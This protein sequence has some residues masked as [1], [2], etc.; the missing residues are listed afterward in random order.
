MLTIVEHEE[1]ALRRQRTDHQL[2]LRQ[3]RLRAQAQSCGD[4][5]GHLIRIEYR[6]ELAKPDPVAEP[7]HQLM[8]H[9]QRQARLADATDAGQRDDPSVGQ[10]RADGFHLTVA[11]EQ[12]HFDPR[13]IARRAFPARA[14]R[15]A[16]GQGAA[17]PGDR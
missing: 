15:P 4:G 6:R 13:K 1:A 11:T 17:G 10:Q 12:L 5:L 7:L 2:L 14:H 9:A 3:T 16:H 8:G